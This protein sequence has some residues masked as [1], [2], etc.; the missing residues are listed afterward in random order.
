MHHITTLILGPKAWLYHYL[1][2]EPE[3][4]SFKF[5]VVACILDYYGFMNTVLFLV[6][7]SRWSQKIQNAARINEKAHLPNSAETNADLE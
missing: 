5:E 7:T 2:Q 3:S 4:E 1:P 6:L